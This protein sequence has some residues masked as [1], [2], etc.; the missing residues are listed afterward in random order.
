MSAGKAIY[1]LLSASTTLAGLVS[2]RIYP[3]IAPFDT[4]Y[5]HIIFTTIDDVP[6]QCMGSTFGMRES[7][8]QVDVYAAD[9][10][11]TVLH[12]ILDRV[13]TILHNYSGST[14]G[15]DVA[16]I[17]LENEQPDLVEDIGTTSAANYVRRGTQD[18]T[19]WYRE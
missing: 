10:Q 3:G 8:V 18:Y 9:P 7:G 12:N 13:E 14:S 16:T 4:A 1:S 5:P 11:L 6:H 17:L 2:T 15:V 19:V